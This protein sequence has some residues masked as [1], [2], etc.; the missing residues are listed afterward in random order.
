MLSCR[1]LEEE[2]MPTTPRSQASL[3]ADQ[4]FLKRLSSLLLQEA[5]VVAAEDIN[6]PN[7]GQRRN[8]AQ[9]IIVN[10]TSMAQSLAP[11]ICNAT[12]LVAA[13]TTYNFEAGC[14]ETDATDAAIQSQIATLWNVLAGV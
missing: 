12:N 2:S 3:A 9:S 6:T 11:A 14:T 10:P 1:K 5:G 13:N 8:L 7:H 4:N